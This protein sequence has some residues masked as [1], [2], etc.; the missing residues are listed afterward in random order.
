VWRAKHRLLARPAAIKLVRRDALGSN[1]RT[2]DVVIHRFER[3]A[4]ET[5]SLRSTHT[6]EV[7]DFGVTEQGDFYYVMELLEGLSLEQLVAR[8]GPV[9]PARLVYLLQQVCHSLGEAHAR[10]LLH[11]DIKPANIFACRLGPDDDFVKVLD[12]GLVKHFDGATTMPTLE[13]MATG[14]PAYMAPELA[15]GRGEVDGRADLYSLGCVAHYLLTGR[16]VFRRKNAIESVLAHLNNEPPTTQRS[17]RIRYSA[18]PRRA[19]SRM[20]RER[21][22]RAS[23]VGHRAAPP[24][25]ADRLVESVDAGRGAHLV[26]TAP[27]DKGPRGAHQIWSRTRGGVNGSCT[28][29]VVAAPG[30]QINADASRLILALKT[31]QTGPRFEH[32]PVDGEV[33][34]SGEMSEWSI[35]HAWKLIPLAR[36][37]AHRTPPKHSRL[38]TLRNSDA[39]RCVP[40]Q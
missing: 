22:G 29:T 30:R 31:L 21:S 4:Q 26:A 9:E 27:R 24:S 17:F 2:R 36:A 34:I 39:H 5:A 40:G 1:Q 38:T 23:V 28:S 18:G 6:V 33:L 25:G 7:Y 37:D 14:T 19:H 20:S 13:G 8:H 32:R 12:F 11:R 16:H 3:E 35:E 10:G 15:L